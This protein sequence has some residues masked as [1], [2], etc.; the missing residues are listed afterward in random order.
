MSTRLYKGQAIGHQQITVNY[1]IGGIGY[2]PTPMM[3]VWNPANPDR[4][5]VLTPEHFNALTSPATR[6]AA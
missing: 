4:W 3:K 1:W 5:I 2:A 6:V